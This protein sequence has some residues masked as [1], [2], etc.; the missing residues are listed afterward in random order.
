MR[1]QMDSA[2]VGIDGSKRPCSTS[3][4]RERSP[5]KPLE[6]ATETGASELSGNDGVLPA[7]TVHSS[8]RSIG[9]TAGQRAAYVVDAQR[10]RTRREMLRE[11]AP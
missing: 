4:S 1:P 3:T 2:L 7:A 10:S 6:S 5:G 9:E 8:W 11:G